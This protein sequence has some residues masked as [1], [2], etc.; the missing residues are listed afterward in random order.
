MNH[1]NSE[2]R[3]RPEDWEKILRKTQFSAQGLMDLAAMMALEIQHMSEFLPKNSRYVP[4][5]IVADVP[6]FRG[7]DYPH[8]RNLKRRSLRA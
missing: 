4:A 8:S 1:E 2:K 5:F 6:F 3:I 7:D